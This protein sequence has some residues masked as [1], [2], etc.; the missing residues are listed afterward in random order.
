MTRLR[1]LVLLAAAVVAMG[2]IDPSARQVYA[3]LWQT[4]IVELGPCLFTVALPASEEERCIPWTRRETASPAFHRATGVLVV[5]GSDGKLHGYDAR[6]GSLRY[7]V[8]MPGRVTAKPVLKDDAA[9]V[10]TEDAHVVRADVTSGRIRWDVPVDAD[11]TTPVT[12]ADDL[13]LVITGMDTVYAF[14]AQTGASRWVHKHPMPSGITLRGQARPEV[15]RVQVG[16]RTETRVY[17]G[18]ATGKLTALELSSG[19]VL[20]E[21]TIGAGETFLDVDADPVQVGD[22]LVVAS[23]ATGVFRVNPATSSTVWK[24][25]EPG[26]VR[27]ASGGPALVVAAGAGKVVGINRHSGQ[28]RWRFEFDKGAPTRIAVQGGRVHVG[29]DRG[30][31]Y[32]LDLFSG[33]PLQ[34]FGSGLGFAADPELLGDMLFVVSTAGR[35]YALS[36]A[37]D[38]RLQRK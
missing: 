3:P 38:G 14:D 6:D 27:L 4:D 20:D 19:R 13:V 31:L 26:F 36:N 35:I 28:V 1:L 21:M 16:D 30:A 12:L 11:V 34:Y 23:H 7:A 32:V 33:R 18:H 22:D 37:F 15:V 10:G 2:A 5:G 17:V 24:V 29:S 9:F 25:E 8:D